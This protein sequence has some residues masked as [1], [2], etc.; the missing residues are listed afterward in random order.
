MHYVKGEYLQENELELLV[1]EVLHETAQSELEYIFWNMFRYDPNNDKNIEFE[2]FAPFILIHSAEIAL[3]RFHMQQVLGKS[4]LTNQEFK[5]IFHE[6]YRFLK[7]LNKNEEVLNN[8]FAELDRNRDG[9][10]TYKEF[11]TWVVL[12]VS[13]TVR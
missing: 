4:S 11:M 10:V 2:E 13:R 9:L 8:I 5:L 7:T 6:A 1:K 12:N 3:Q